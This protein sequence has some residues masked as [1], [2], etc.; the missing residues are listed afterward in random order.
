MLRNEKK[1]EYFLFR[2]LQ[3]I[4]SVTPFW[5]LYFFSDACSFIIQYILRYRYKTVYS[6]LKASFPLK[7]KK[8]LRQITRNF[9]KN[10][11]D[12]ALES[13]KGY[14]LNPVTI[15]KRYRCINPEIADKFFESGQDVIIAMSH[16]G[17]WEWGTQAAASIF[18]QKVYAFYKPMSNCYINKFILK[19]RMNNKM[20][21][22]SIYDSKFSIRSNHEKPK[23]YFMV[24]DQSPGSRKKAYWVKFLNHETACLHGIESYARLFN[25][26][27]IFCNV[28][29]VKR[30]YYTI[31][32]KLL[33]P[34]P[35]ITC[36]SEITVL[37]MRALEKIII[38]KPEDWLW[39]HRR[40]KMTAPSQVILKSKNQVFT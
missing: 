15:L 26:P 24:S 35:L 13:I 17:N 34:N 1:L 39:S 36:V 16:Y 21:F 18:R 23:A 37:Y 28:Q 8:R 40:W 10:L 25:L 20:Q 31:E 19:K 9:Y 32:L 33:C 11:C 7:S 14:S 4:L 3:I 29:R 5:L 38:A 2:L 12:I 22:I 30:G 6:N 27:V